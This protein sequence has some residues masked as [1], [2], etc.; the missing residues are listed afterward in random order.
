M[1]RRI[2]EDANGITIKCNTIQTD[3]L[4]TFAGVTLGD[5]TDYIQRT[6]LDVLTADK[7]I[8]GDGT[9]KI[10][11]S[12]IDCANDNIDLPSSK[13]YKINGTSLLNHDGTNYNLDNIDNIRSAIDENINIDA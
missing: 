13:A 11:D 3:T 2:T 9:N 7:I 4:P 5:P 1:L 10:K 12:L 8:I 6:A